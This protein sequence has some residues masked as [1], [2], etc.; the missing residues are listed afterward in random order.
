MRVVHVL[1]KPLSEGTV[2]SNTLKHG[3]GGINID[4]S[5][6][7]APGETIT[8]HSRGADS[9]ISK[10]IHGDSKGQETHQT[11]GQ[12]R[13]R[14]PANVI[15]QHLG[16]CRREGTRKIKACGVGAY[17][18]STAK[19]RNGQTGAAYGAESRPE[20]TEYIN[21]AD[22]DGNEAVANWICAEGCP[23]A[24]LD[25]QSGDWPVSGAAKIGSRGTEYCE[26]GGVTYYQNKGMGV[27]HNDTGGASRYYKQ[28]GGKKDG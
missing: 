20:G 6:V 14:W 8:N 9:A 27:V 17:K 15:L 26:G 22:K 21:Y 10:G 1:R 7:A 11:G 3:C 24:A 4:A 18:R 16:G 2:A 19:D 5:R 13:G 23:V 28:V 25:E 12:K